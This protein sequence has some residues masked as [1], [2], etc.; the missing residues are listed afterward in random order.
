MD[1]DRYDDEFLDAK[2][3]LRMWKESL[4]M[5]D[6]RYRA[7]ALLRLAALSMVSEEYRT[8]LVNDTQA[9]LNEMRLLDD[10]PMGVTLRFHENT[11]ETLHVVLPPRRQ[12]LDSRPPRFRELLRSRT[13][14]NSFLLDDVDLGDWTDLIPNGVADGGDAAILDIPIIFLPETE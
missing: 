7:K 8:R 14:E 5:Q 12:E 3:L 13:S 1:S 6:T 2:V 9:V 4:V 10:L 11:A